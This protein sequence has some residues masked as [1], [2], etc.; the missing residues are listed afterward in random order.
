GRLQD[1]GQDVALVLV[2]TPDLETR[3]AGH[4][5]AQRLDL[6]RADVDPVDVEELDVRKRT[7]VQLLEDLVRLRTLDLVAVVRAQD[8]LAFRTR[9]RTR[10]VLDAHVP[11][12][13]SGAEHQPVR[14][15]SAAD[16]DELVLAL[17][18]DDVVA[19][20]VAGRGDRNVVLRTVQVEV[21]EGVDAVIR[22]KLL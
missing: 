2:R 21:M 11:L 22:K 4:A 13:V 15:R 3:S 19:D 5:V 8:A 9:R 16:E 14:G 17:T 1:L 6:L 7:A 12:A 18:E 20:D 10:V